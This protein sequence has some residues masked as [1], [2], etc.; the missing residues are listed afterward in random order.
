MSNDPYQV[1]GSLTNDAPSYVSRSADEELYHALKAGKFCYVLN[2]RQMGKSSVLVRTRY[3][4]S[5]EG[6]RCTTLDMTRIGSEN[7]TPDQW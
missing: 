7:I 4:L 1:G 5:Q 6:Y 3:R 2:C